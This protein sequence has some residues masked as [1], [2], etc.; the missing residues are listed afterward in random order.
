MTQDEKT[1]FTR[2]AA[3]LILASMLTR[4]T[5]PAPPPIYDPEDD[6]DQPPTEARLKEIAELNVGN[7]TRHE[8]A[9]NERR[10]LYAMEAFAF[11]TALAAE[12][13]LYE[14]PVD[15]DGVALDERAYDRECIHGRKSSEPCADCDR[16]EAAA[17]A[18]EQGKPA[19]G[20]DGLLNPA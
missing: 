17:N 13:E 8:H 16:M 7:R 9:C 19:E 6:A 11:A 2:Q 4:Y 3:A 10:A 12:S 14:G 18:E 15:G 1:E 5:R 20:G